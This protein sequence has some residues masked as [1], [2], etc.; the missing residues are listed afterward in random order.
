MVGKW[1]E[2]LKEVAPA[3]P[4]FS[5]TLDCGCNWRNRLE[6]LGVL[7]RW[8]LQLLP[9]QLW[10]NTTRGSKFFVAKA[11]YRVSALYQAAEWLTL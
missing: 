9:C 10:S 7:M 11:E 3:E 6:L 2:M 5:D 4:R 8:S 1:L